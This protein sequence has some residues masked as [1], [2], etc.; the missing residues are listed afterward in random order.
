MDNE[1]EDSYC[2]ECHCET[3]HEIEVHQ[4]LTAEWNEWVCQTCG[5]RTSAY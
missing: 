4:S 1:I 2:D 5:E 3:S